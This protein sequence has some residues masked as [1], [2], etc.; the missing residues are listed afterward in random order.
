V[1]LNVD[2]DNPTGAVALYER[3]G[4]RKVRGWDIYEKRIT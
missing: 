4:M 3:V 1:R 2:A